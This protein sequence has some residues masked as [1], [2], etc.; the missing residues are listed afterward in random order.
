MRD[1]NWLF[2]AAAYA[3]TW[4]I[5]AGYAVHL[6]RTGR[7]ARRMLAQASAESAPGG[8]RK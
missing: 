2:V 6:F 5:I 1:S 7:R 4:I 3:A 8:R